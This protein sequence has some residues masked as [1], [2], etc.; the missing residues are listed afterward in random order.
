MVPIKTFQIGCGEPWGH[1][2]HRTTSRPTPPSG[3]CLLRLSQ[4]PPAP[5]T[6]L[7]VHALFSRSWTCA[8]YATIRVAAC[9]IPRR[10]ASPRVP[11]S[12]CRR[13]DTR[14]LPRQ[15]RELTQRGQGA[16]NRR[17]LPT[18]RTNKACQGCHPCRLRPVVT[19]RVGLPRFHLG[20]Q[21][22]VRA[23]N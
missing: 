15:Q 8:Y 22:M 7:C 6:D 16:T 20:R 13:C 4:V 19:L 23:W 1:R 21:E 3:H 9:A 11:S 12:A 2:D 14:N 17:L 5:W 10:R 18:N